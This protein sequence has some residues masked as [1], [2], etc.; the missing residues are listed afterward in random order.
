MSRS[1]ARRNNKVSLNRWDSLW[2]EEEEEEE[3]GSL[4][5]CL[6]SD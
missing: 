1:Q 6:L 5:E 3:V 4:V 2:E